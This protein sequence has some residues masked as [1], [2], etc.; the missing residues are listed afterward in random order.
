M[1]KIN[2]KI[3]LFILIISAALGLIF[4]LV[5]ERG[6]PLA[7][8]EKTLKW[9]AGILSLPLNS[10]EPYAINLQQA[11]ELYEQ[12]EIFIDAREKEDFESSHIKGAIN[13]PF[14]NIDEYIPDI[15]K[16][17][18]E[19]RIITYCG[20]TECDLSILLGNKLSEMGYK[21]VYIFFGGWNKWIDAGLPVEGKNKK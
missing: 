12:N 17:P 1:S 21:N 7:A 4:N 10:N 8:Q 16:I 18:K 19:N 6:I 9:K 3:V 15:N 14:D 11:K 5:N 2:Y 13:I 20:G